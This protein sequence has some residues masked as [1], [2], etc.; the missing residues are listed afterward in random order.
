MKKGIIIAFAFVMI[1]VSGCSK[2]TE[3]TE[4]G[5]KNKTSYAVGYDM[6]TKTRLTEISNELDVDSLVE[7][8][9]DALNDKEA[10]ISDEDRQ[11]IMKQ[12]QEDMTKKQL[13][14][15]KKQGETNKVSGKAYLDQNAKDE[16]VKVTKSGL[17]YEIIREGT[18]PRAKAADKVKVHYSGTLIDGTEFDSSYK[19]GEPAVF[20]L[21]GIIGGWREGLQLMKVGS[22]YHFVI[23][24]ELAYGERGMGM[25][26]PPFSVLVFDIELIG[27]EPPDLK[28]E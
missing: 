2:S 27:I 10:K 11:K 20:N 28:Q 3:K 25:K 18:G 26:I 1:L 9:T 16:G 19:R 14:D 7:G 23:P 24:S 17:Q 22:K 5:D 21:D 6:A 4:K 12:F 13:D 8:L 15:R